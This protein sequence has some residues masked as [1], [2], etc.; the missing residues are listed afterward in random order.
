MDRDVGKKFPTS[1]SNSASGASSF[2]PEI[3][4]GGQT[5]SESVD[6]ALKGA[7]G[8]A[9]ERAQKVDDDIKVGGGEREDL[10]SKAAAKQP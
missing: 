6:E 1:S 9:T 8:L 2:L 5:W 3:R 10:H 4:S 7:Q